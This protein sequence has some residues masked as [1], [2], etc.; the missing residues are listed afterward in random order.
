MSEARAELPPGWRILAF[1]AVG[2]TN[3]EAM[4]LARAGAAE[5]TLVWARTQTAGRGRRG[6]H[7]VSPPGNLYAS[8][9]LRPRAAP[10]QAAQ[11]SFVAA[12]AL[13][14]ALEGSVPGLAGLA[15]KW[16]NDILVKGRK[17]A[18][19]LLESEARAGDAASFVVVGTGVN[20]VSAP[21]ETAYPATS[22]CAEGLKPPAPERLLG[23]YAQ[24]FAA[25]MAR[26]QRQGFAPVG[27]AWRLR[28][29]ALGRPIEVRLDRTV[30][31]GRFRDIDEEGALVLEAAGERRRV[32]AGEV[33]PTSR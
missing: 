3:D 28:A 9:I 2:S 27:A 30:L 5:G 26:W 31:R 13:G 15:Y 23:E 24:G 22:L 25:W 1:D 19:I 17:L 4:R 20:L 8:L 6:R 7:W 14:E 18:G 10:G 21:S 12:L 29:A 16:P 32:A 11:L 33:F